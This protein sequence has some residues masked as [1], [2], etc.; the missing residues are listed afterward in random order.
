VI[1]HSWCMI[2]VREMLWSLLLTLMA[3]IYSLYIRDVYFLDKNSTA[4]VHVASKTLS[5]LF[6]GQLLSIVLK[7]G[8]VIDSVRVL[9]HWVIGSTIGSL[10]EPHD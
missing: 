8:P 9:G 5:F 7:L 1:I 4:H 3:L 10:V 6:K 2:F